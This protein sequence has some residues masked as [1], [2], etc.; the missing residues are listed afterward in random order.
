MVAKAE[1]GAQRRLGQRREDIEISSC[2]VRMTCDQVAGHNDQIGLLLHQ[3]M[4]DLRQ[5]F[6][7]QEY[8]AVNVRN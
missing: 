2:L 5:S 4:D 8:S 6:R 1:P 7:F 3:G